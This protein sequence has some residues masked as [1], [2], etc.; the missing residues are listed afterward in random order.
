MQ[1]VYLRNG[2]TC[3]YS[4]NQQ[5]KTQIEYSDLRVCVYFVVDDDACVAAVVAAAVATLGTF[6]LLILSVAFIHY[7]LKIIYSPPQVA[8]ADNN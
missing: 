8:N 7:P 5:R 6:C 1:R 3:L 4:C 2:G